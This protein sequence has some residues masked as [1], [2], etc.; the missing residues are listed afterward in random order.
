MIRNGNKLERSPSLLSQLKD[1]YSKASTAS[2]KISEEVKAWD[3]ERERAKNNATSSSDV[4]GGFEATSAGIS[5][6][7]VKPGDLDGAELPAGTVIK[8]W[9]EAR[10][11]RHLYDQGTS[12]LSIGEKE[13]MYDEGLHGIKINE[14]RRIHVPAPLGYGAEGFGHDVPPDATLEFQ[15]EVLRARRG[16][17]WVTRWN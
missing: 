6:V 7:T 16:S 11:N 12:M 14:T 9:Y 10:A 1:R 15:V 2:S 17:E 13:V 8:V 3:D 4:N 5:Y